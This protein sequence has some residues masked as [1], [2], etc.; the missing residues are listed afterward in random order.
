M[1]SRRQLQV[2]ASTSFQRWMSSSIGLAREHLTQKCVELAVRAMTYSSHPGENVLDL[3]GGSAST[4]IGAEQ[5]QRHA[6]LMELD[7]LYCD[8]IVERFEKFTGRKAKRM[9]QG[10]AA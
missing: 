1:S 2:S 10:Q 6:F 5:T 4:L 3:F 8:V 7:A 9:A